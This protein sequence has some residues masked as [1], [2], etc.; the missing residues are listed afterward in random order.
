[1]VYRCVLIQVSQGEYVE[2]LVRSRRA[3]SQDASVQYE[4]REE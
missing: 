1:M 4:Q 3:G 2:D